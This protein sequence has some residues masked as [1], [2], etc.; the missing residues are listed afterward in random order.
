MKRKPGLKLLALVAPLLGLFLVWHTGQRARDEADVCE[1]AARD[2]ISEAGQAPEI[3]IS[4]NGKDPLTTFLDRFNGAVPPI[5]AASA[6]TPS[7]IPLNQIAAATIRAR[8]ATIMDIQSVRWEANGEVTVKIKLMRPRPLRSE[9]FNCVLE[10]QGEYWK[11]IR[12]DI[13]DTSI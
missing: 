10:R 7:R 8:R 6:R 4:I 2:H 5:L 12:H 3:F 1:A 13:F 11:P 9:V